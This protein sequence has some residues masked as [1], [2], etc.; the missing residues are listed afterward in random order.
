[1]M[2]KKDFRWYLL[3][4]LKWCPANAVEWV[5]SLLK[6]P[7]DWVTPNRLRI[8]MHGS[9]H[10]FCHPPFEFYFCACRL[11]GRQEQKKKK[12]PAASLSQAMQRP[13]V[14]QHK[15]ICQIG[16]LLQP[17]ALFLI[18]ELHRV[19]WIVI[20]MGHWVLKAIFLNPVISLSALD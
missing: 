17:K 15:Y 20:S 7:T 12:E 16:V 5:Q 13:E 14:T 8:H 10:A 9:E 11:S 1:M 2:K 6:M 3:L 19:I 18:G 4:L